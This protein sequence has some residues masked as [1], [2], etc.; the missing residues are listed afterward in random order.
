MVAGGWVRPEQ[1]QEAAAAIALSEARPSVPSPCDVAVTVAP[2]AEVAGAAE[3]A[4]FTVGYG[5]GAPESSAT[6]VD[7]S[8]AGWLRGSPATSEIA[9]DDILAA[10][11]TDPMSMYRVVSVATLP[12]PHPLKTSCMRQGHAPG[13]SGTWRWWSRLGQK[14]AQARLRDC[15]WYH[16]GDWALACGFAVSEVQKAL[17]EGVRWSEMSQFVTAAVKTSITDPW[18]A[19]AITSLLDPVSAM[20][21]DEGRAVIVDGHHRAFVM[22]QQGVNEALV[23]WSTRPDRSEPTAGS[24]AG[25]ALR[26]MNSEEMGA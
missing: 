25:S 21:L 9:A 4:T 22:R 10:E 24:P 18:Q 7:T 5:S 14:P 19:E 2:T 23:L 6:Q 3:H 26:A 8:P 1:L 13:P 20:I 17:A 12:H 15:C 16:R 11:R